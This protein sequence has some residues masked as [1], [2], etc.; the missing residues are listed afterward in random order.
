MASNSASNQSVTA[1]SVLEGSGVFQHLIYH[2]RKVIK[3]VISI[4]FEYKREGR[5]GV[6]GPAG[7]A[8]PC[9]QVLERRKKP[10]RLRIQGQDL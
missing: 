4:L 6:K 1:S 7:V 5:E 10:F 3:D 9:Q 2:Q 8:Q